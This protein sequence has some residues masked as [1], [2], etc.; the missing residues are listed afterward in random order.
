MAGESWVSIPSLTRAEC[1]LLGNLARL[2]RLQWN[3]ES[4][5]TPAVTVPASLLSTV[6]LLERL[7][8]L[9]TVPEGKARQR[10]RRR[11]G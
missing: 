1:E 9:A 8:G 3:L 10:A 5:A 2:L 7:A 4:G 6:E 11:P